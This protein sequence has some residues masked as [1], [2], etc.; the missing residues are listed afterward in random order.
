MIAL[1][2]HGK[3]MNG[4][5]YTSNPEQALRAAHETRADRNLDLNAFAVASTEGSNRGDDP[6]E[7]IL[8][9]LPWRQ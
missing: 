6:L 7:I 4:R 9:R 2:N 3:A 1:G 8:G 5:W